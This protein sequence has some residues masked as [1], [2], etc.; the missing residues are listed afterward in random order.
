VT[1]ARSMEDSTV[2]ISKSLAVYHTDSNNAI[3]ERLDK[4]EGD[5]T[6]IKANL[7]DIHRQQIECSSYGTLLRPYTAE[8]V[9][10]YD[11]ADPFFEGWLCYDY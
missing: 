10:G 3:S 9:K 8:R 1:A 5:S 11:V 4:I 6:E 2:H 7:G